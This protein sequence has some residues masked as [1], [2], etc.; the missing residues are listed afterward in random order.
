MK[1]RT[2][3]LGQTIGQIDSGAFA[4]SAP[5]LV[6]WVPC[7]CFPLFNHYFYRKLSLYIHIPNI[8]LQLGFE[9]EP[10]RIGDLAFACP[11][12]CSCS[13]P[14]SV[15]YPKSHISSF[16][17]H[18]NESCTFAVLEPFGRNE[19][20]C[21]LLKH[22]TFEVFSYFYGQNKYKIR[23]SVSV[24]KKTVNFGYK[25]YFLRSKSNTQSIVCARVYTVKLWVHDKKITFFPINIKFHLHMQSEK[26]LDVLLNKK[27]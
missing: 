15:E 9:F 2:F 17:K 8:Y 23:I 26:S 22:P 1:S 20:F 27:C 24:I 25:V 6:Q 10:Q 11:L 21:I 3:V 4:V 16:Y 13:C 18:S 19:N 7:P 5:V 12:F 14:C